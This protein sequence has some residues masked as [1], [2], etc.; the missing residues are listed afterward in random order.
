MGARYVAASVV[1]A[2]LAVGCAKG[3]SDGSVFGDGP[4]TGI[5]SG[6]P[7]TYRDFGTFGE[8][9]DSGAAPVAEGCAPS[10]ANYEI[11]S[12]GCDDDADGEVDNVVRCDAA[13]AIDGDG[14]AFANAIGICQRATDKKWG[15]VSADFTDGHT[16][17]AP[18][19]AEQHG[20]LPRFGSN[21]SPREGNALGVLSSGF[22][23]EFDG[24]GDEAFKGDK[25]MM[26][27]GQSPLRRRNNAPPGFP[28]ASK[29][30]P[31]A[32]PGT[33]DLIDLRLIL[34]APAN[35]KGL[36]FDFNFYSGEWPEYVCSAFNDSFVAY[37]S[38]KGFNDGRADNMSFDPQG[39]PVSVNNGFF[40]RCTPNTLAGCDG[41]VPASAPCDGGIA[42]LLGT[43]FAKPGTYCTT[44]STGGGA[45]GW[46]TSTAPVTPGQIIQ[47]ELMIW[48][49]GDWSFD[50]TVLVDHFQW[51][52]IPV[53]AGTERALK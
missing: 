5:D 20:I 37:L 33:F 34:R 4:P 18:P 12:N 30:C 43:G 32:A 38:A 41:R 25:A 13:L 44:E 10:P 31:A 24:S 21:V 8:T 23:R 29:G 1:A 47:L 17:T 39:N 52:P 15:L 36:R 2:S 6:A 11:P 35:A 48:D 40:D 50:S 27:P 19:A 46:L 51:V 26:Q 16:S 9:V 3:P 28:K 14:T 42:E 49:T 22:A 45:T 53:E 7:G